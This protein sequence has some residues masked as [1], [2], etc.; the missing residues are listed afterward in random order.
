MSNPNRDDKKDPT[1][2]PY[3]IHFCEWC[4]VG[5]AC[6]NGPKCD[7]GTVDGYCS[8]DCHDHRTVLWQVRV[9]QPTEYL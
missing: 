5:M 6:Y 8:Q 9:G 4:G 7:M 2:G 1:M 3:H